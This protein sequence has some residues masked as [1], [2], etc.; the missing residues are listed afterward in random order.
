MAFVK[1]EAIK[2]KKAMN[3]YALKS[4]LYLSSMKAALNEL[5]AIKHGLQLELEF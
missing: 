1:L 3:Q 5:N 4:T 2:I